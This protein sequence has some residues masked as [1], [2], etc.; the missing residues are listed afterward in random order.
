MLEENNSISWTTNNFIERIHHTI[1]STYS[2]KQTVLSFLE[3]LYG[4]KLSQENIIENS[5]TNNFEVGLVTLFNV[6]SV[7]QKVIQEAGGIQ[8]NY[9]IV[10]I[11]TE[12]SHIYSDYLKSQNYN[13]FVKDIMCKL[14]QYFKNKQCV[15]PS[16]SKN[17]LIYNGSIQKAYQEIIRLYNLQENI[18]LSTTD[19]S[20]AKFILL[21]LKKARFTKFNFAEFE[22]ADELE[23]IIDN[24]DNN[25]EMNE[26]CPFCDKILSNP[27]SNQIKLALDKINNNHIYKFKDIFTEIINDT[28]Y[29]IIITLQYN[30]II[31]L[32]GYKKAV[33]PMMLIG[34]FQTFR[35][36]YYGIKGAILITNILIDLFLTFNILTPINSFPLTPQNYIQEILV[37]ETV[38][39]LILKDISNS[40]LESA[41][42]IMIA[43]SDF[44][45]YVHNYN[46]ES[47]ELLN[48]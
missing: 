43:S 33:T 14:V 42:N 31:I 2:G 29:I 38:T 30:Y 10:N 36:G 11:I 34:R 26:I 20:N 39:R 37:P 12:E 22:S 40:S 47:K 17:L 5:G 21:S 25:Y 1:E 18:Q 44:G 6:Q 4:I 19:F 15:L 46:N 23:S 3:R 16:F 13:E 48:H 8:S 32:L 45:E 28:A 35:P 7:E 24:N 41:R 27:M 9:Y